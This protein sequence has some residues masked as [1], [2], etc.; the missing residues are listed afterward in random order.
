MSAKELAAYVHDQLRGLPGV[1]S[2]AMMGGYVFYYQEKIFGG[3]YEAGFLVKD[4]PA[5]RAAMPGAEDLPPYPGGKNMLCCTV[6]DDRETLQAMVNAMFDELPL[7]K[8][9]KKRT[10]LQ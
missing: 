2:R 3:I 10:K 9:K 8:P 7:P 6:L 1:T 5:A 4:T